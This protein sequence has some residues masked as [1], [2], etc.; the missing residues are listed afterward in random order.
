[1]HLLFAVVVFA[2]V[3]ADFVVGVVLLLKSVVAGCRLYR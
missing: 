1:M 3:G 2:S